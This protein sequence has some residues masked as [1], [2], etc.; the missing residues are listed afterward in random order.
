[1]STQLR[2]ARVLIADDQTLF[3]SGLAQ[4]LDGDPRVEVVG[5]AA[6][7]L[8][9]VKQAGSLKPD[10]VLMDLKMPNLDGI[11]AT[12]RILAEHP[13]IKVLVLTS[14]D[15][16]NLV[17]QALRAGAS[18][19]V[20]KD[21]HAEAVVSSILA[22]LAG[23]RVMASAVANRVV[24]MLSGTTS[25]KEFYDGLTAREI[26]ILKLIAIGLANKQIAHRLSISE[27][28]VRNHV[29][30]LYE[31]LGIYDRTQAVLYA[32]RKGLVEL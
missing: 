16:D 18:G 3:R 10:V 23:E 1:M 31:K 8:D 15:T 9:V 4:L 24:G 13:E 21:S 20:L 12:R 29:S 19:Y 26:E 5:Q 32:V 2:T 30:N 27:K 17:L 25:P 28:T 22:V 6:D 14:F 11:E 7:G